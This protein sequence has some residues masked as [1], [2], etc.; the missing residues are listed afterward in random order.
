MKHNEIEESK[1][2]NFPPVSVFSL[3]RIITA[4]FFDQDHT[5]CEKNTADT[6]EIDERKPNIKE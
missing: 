4:G 3:C 6:I 5:D 2:S 1:N